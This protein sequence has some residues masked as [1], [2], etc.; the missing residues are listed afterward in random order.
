[1]SAVV[2]SLPGWGGGAQRVRK[3]KA[4]PLSIHHTHMRKTVSRGRRPD[5]RQRVKMGIYLFGRWYDV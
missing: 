4:R 2:T 1:M 3:P 5:P